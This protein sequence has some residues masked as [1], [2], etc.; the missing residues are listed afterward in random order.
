MVS[1]NRSLQTMSVNYKSRIFGSVRHPNLNFSGCP[2][3]HDSSHKLLREEYCSRC[4]GVYDKHVDLKPWS[5]GVRLHVYCIDYTA[6]V[7]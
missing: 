5:V 4:V 6:Q 7:H 3:T 1:G 2:E